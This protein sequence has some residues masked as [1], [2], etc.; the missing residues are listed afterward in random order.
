[1][2]AAAIVGIFVLIALGGLALHQWSAKRISEPAP[3]RDLRDLADPSRWPA[4]P[5]ED[6][7]AGEQDPGPP[8]E[9]DVP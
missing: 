8:G 6:A 5:P 2:T 1:M 4:P 3:D 9:G 7:D